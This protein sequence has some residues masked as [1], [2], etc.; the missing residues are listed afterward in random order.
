MTAALSLRV[1]P[2][3]RADRVVGWLDDGSL[4]L[5]VSAPP[6]DGR[7]NEAVIALLAHI[8]AVPRSAVRITAGASARRKRVEFEGVDP[9]QVKRRL[10]AALEAGTR[11][12]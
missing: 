12:E 3:A 4:K 9:V 5:E 11:G 8:V 6:E 10:D 7:A 2:S 1:R